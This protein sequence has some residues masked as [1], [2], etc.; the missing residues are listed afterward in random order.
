MKNDKS[1][2]GDR[3]SLGGEEA[4]RAF[5]IWLQ[6]NLREIFKSIE[7]EPLPQQLLDIIENDRISRSGD[8]SHSSVMEDGS[9]HVS[10]DAVVPSTF[11]SGG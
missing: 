7:S 5:D 11:V 4:S 3:F 10:D 1:I 2:Q 8:A 6:R 9:G